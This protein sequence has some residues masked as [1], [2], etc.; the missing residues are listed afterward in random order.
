MDQR[1]DNLGKPAVVLIHGSADSPASWRALIPLLEAA[2]SVDAPAFPPYPEPPGSV[3]PALGHAPPWLDAQ[4]ERSGARVLVAHSY[5]AL[6][7]LRWALA[8]PGRLDKLV[9]CE[10]IAWGVAVA[11]PQVAARLGELDARCVQRFVAG[12]RETPMRWLVDFWNGEGF[13]DALPERI[14]V[15]LLAGAARTCAEVASGGADRTDAAELAGL[16]VATTLIAGARTPPESLQVSRA[17]VAAVPGARFVELP[18]V[19]HQFLRS[20]AQALA[21]AIGAPAAD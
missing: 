3:G 15:G 17:I 11:D 5:G 16:S 6:L 19:G 18:D 9:L 14:R 8:H 7:A 1:S 20:H 12:E 21:A 13:W 4:M 2:W 10:P